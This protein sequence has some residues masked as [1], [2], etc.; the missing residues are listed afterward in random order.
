MSND[1]QVCSSERV[2]RIT[3]GNIGTSMS[4][5]SV[6][7]KLLSKQIGLGNVFRLLVICAFV[8]IFDV[9]IRKKA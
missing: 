7:V 6:Q 4:N 3:K 1:E 5:A 8:G 9:K 2:E